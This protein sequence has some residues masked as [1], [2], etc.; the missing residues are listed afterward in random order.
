[1]R[2]ATA[3]PPG[4]AA[5]MF[6]ADQASGLLGIELL[7]QGAGTAVLRM[8]VTASMV[9]GHGIAHGGYVFLLADT[10]FACAC[11]SHG[12]VTVASGADVTF[13]AP[14]REGDVLTA[15][16]WEVTRFGRSG[17][18]DVTVVRGET[19]VAEFRGRSRSL[20]SGENEEAR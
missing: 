14:A 17:I 8:T 11:N 2:K 15:S 19:V 20:R 6:A 3:A 12:P 4:P 1:M 10:A 16:A 9:N 5:R 13:V 7:E 18:Y